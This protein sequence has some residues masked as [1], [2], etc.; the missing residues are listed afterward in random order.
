VQTIT[1]DRLAKSHDELIG[2]CTALLNAG[3]SGVI[4]VKDLGCTREGDCEARGVTRPVIYDE[5]VG[6]AGGNI[7]ARHDRGLGSIPLEI[8]GLG[9]I[10]V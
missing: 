5:D 6:L 9:V 1:A 4:I 7:E 8:A 10:G 2:V 3:D